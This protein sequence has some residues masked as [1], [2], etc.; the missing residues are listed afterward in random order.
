MIK[1]E[2]KQDKVS[3]NQISAAGCLHISGA[4][5]LNVSS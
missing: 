5:N 3:A 4:D 1:K 2:K